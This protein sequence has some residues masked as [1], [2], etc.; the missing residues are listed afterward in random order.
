[1]TGGEAFAHDWIDAFNARDLDRILRHY[2]ADIELV[3][4]IYLGFTGGR[5]DMVRGTAA[6]RDYFA[7]ALERHP[8]LRFTLL[9]VACGTRSIAIRYH[10]NLGNRVAIECFEGPPKGPASRVLCHY[11]GAAT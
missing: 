9:E 8:A 3:S 11:V 5:T 10:T 4:P 1:M 6:L 7:Q 2:S